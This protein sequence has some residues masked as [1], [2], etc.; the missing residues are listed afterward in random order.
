VANLCEAY[1]AR[2]AKVVAQKGDRLRS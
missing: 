2:L 1:P